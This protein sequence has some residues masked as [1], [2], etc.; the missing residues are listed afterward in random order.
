MMTKADIKGEIEQI[1]EKLPIEDLVDL[2]RLSDELR[3][4]SYGAGHEDGKSKGYDEG[5]SEGYDY[6][7][8]ENKT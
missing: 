5:Y 1:G 7:S 4:L 8:Q 6:G 2:L 3:K